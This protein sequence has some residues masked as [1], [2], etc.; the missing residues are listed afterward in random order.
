MKKT[1]NTLKIK[2]KRI[3]ENDVIRTSSGAPDVLNP[4]TETTPMPFP[5]FTPANFD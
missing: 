1:Y 5:S 4:G 2:V 3:Q